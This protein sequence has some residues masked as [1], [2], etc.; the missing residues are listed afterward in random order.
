MIRWPWQKRET[1]ADSSYTDALVAAITANAGGQSTAFPTATAALEAC[2]GFVGRAFT[3]AEVRGSD[4]IRDLLSPGCL[5]MVGRALIRRGE[6]VLLI[7]VEGGELRLLPCESHDIDGGPDPAGWSYRCTVGGPERTLTYNGVPA[8]SVIHVRYAVDVERPWRG[9]G[10][11]GVAQLAGRLSA[12]TSAA[13]AD[14][15]GMPR[16]ALLP[17]PLPGDSEQLALAK[18]DVRGLKGQIGFVE[19]MNR[20]AAG[21]AGPSRDWVPNRIGAE[22]PASLVALH[23]QAFNEVVSACGLSPTLF[24]MQGDG[25]AQRESFRRAL[26]AT[27]APLGR[28]VQSEL[29]RKMEVPVELDFSGLFAA[30]VQGRARAWRSLVG[31]EAALDPM[32]AARLVGLE[33]D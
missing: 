27:I 1:R 5:G 28:I 2:S 26:H 6:V 14:E 20:L 15:A 8:E 3:S 16:G 30:D 7:R 12:E 4:A 11:L 24:S 29:S 22:P 13:L 32:V 25:T 21:G 23:Q 9:Y 31:N 19:S 17:T 10:P 18:A 33:T